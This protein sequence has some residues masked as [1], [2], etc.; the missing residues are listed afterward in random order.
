MKY[1]FRLYGDKEESLF[2]IFK[3]L[4]ALKGF[5]IR[6]RLLYLIEMDVSMKGRKE[7]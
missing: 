3:S 6:E 5:S 1:L 4:C 2:T 7:R